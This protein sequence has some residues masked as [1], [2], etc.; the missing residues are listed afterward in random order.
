MT[1]IVVITRCLRTPWSTGENF[2]FTC[3]HLGEPG[4]TVEQYG[5]IIFVG[6]AAGARV[7]RSYYFSFNASAKCILVTGSLQECLRGYGM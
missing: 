5:K 6:N 3:E 4:I 7:N 1:T 2:G